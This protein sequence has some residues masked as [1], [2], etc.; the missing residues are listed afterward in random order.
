MS[1]KLRHGLKVKRLQFGKFGLQARARRAL[2]LQC[3]SPAYPD[4]SVAF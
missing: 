4:N 1:E 2:W 3:A